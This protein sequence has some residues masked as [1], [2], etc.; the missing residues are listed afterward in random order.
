MQKLVT[1]NRLKKIIKK[2]RDKKII[3]F[4]NG[5]FDILHPGH[6]KILKFAKS[7]GDILIVGLNSDRSIK[8]IKGKNRPILNQKARSYLLS[9]ISFVDYIVIFDEKTPLQLIKSLKPDYLVKGEDW[10]KVDIVGKEYVKKVFRVKH[11][12]GYSTT[13]IIKTI[14]KKTINGKNL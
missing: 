9:A 12:P 14:L 5:C 3:V 10:K 1:L 13:N 7:K 4:T 6:I 11:Y 2:E 8:K